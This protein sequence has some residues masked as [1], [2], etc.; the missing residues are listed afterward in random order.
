M[1]RKKCSVEHRALD[2]SLFHLT[3]HQYT[4]ENRIT[5]KRLNIYRLVHYSHYSLHNMSYDTL[6][7]IF[8]APCSITL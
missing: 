2:Y 5:K 3:T 1:L 6:I 4:D 8:R 7:E